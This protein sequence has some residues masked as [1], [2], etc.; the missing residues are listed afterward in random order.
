MGNVNFWRRNI[1][2]LWK[3]T[4]FEEEMSDFNGKLILL[5]EEISDSGGKCQLHC[6]KCLYKPYASLSCHWQ[7][8]FIV[9]VGK[10]KP[11]NMVSIVTQWKAL[12][13]FLHLLCLEEFPCIIFRCLVGNR[14]I[15]WLVK[16]KLSG[17]WTTNSLVGNQE[18]LCLVGD[19]LP[20]WWMT[21]CLVGE[22]Q[23]LWLVNDKS[24]GW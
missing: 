16:G 11:K 24:S 17:W 7:E 15:I 19:K 20:G 6:L 13:I 14:H 1:R 12:H 23:I 9:T 10:S 22:R 2:F 8:E 3:M 4:I 5:D 18:I 21:N